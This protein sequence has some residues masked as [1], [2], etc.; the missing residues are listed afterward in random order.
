MYTLPPLTV[1]INTGA[2]IVG[3]LTTVILAAPGAGLAYRVR[4]VSI[5]VARSTAAAIVDQFLRS[6]TTN[7][8]IET[9]AGLQVAGSP[10]FAIDYAYPGTQIPSNEG[11]SLDSIST[12]ATGLTT[13]LVKYYIDRLN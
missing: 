7:Y 4:E 6:T 13:C 1:R 2:H 8:P 5:W 10:G 9:F 3:T 12:A 11:I